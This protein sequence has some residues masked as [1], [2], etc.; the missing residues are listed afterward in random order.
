MGLALFCAIAVP[1]C[2]TQADPDT[3]LVSGTVEAVETELGAEVAGVLKE[4]PVREGDEVGQGQVVAR[5]DPSMYLARLAE[6]RA[7][8]REAEAM[9][10]LS[11][12]GFRKEE[13]LAA[14]NGVSEMEASLENAEANLRRSE[15]LFSQGVVSK[16]DLDEARR[17][18]DVSRA[19]LKSA[20]ENYRKLSSGL[21]TEDIEAARARVERSRA[22]VEQARLD[23]L[24]TEVRSPRPGVV[25]QAIREPG[26]FVIVGTPILTI[27]DLTGD[28]YCWVYLSERELSWV[29]LG[30]EVSAKI[31]AYPDH[32][33]RGKVAFISR[34]A[35]FTPRNVQT[36]EDRVNLV[37]AVKISLANPDGS[38]KVGLP[39]DVELRIRGP[40]EGAAGN[41]P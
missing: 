25:T 19:R 28:I 33:F 36:R 13:I 10:A 6:A 32:R 1:S 14:L 18:A 31:D 37:F 5:I 16:F 11:L 7:A 27:A 24:R 26:E 34:E 39:I 21:R 12:E 8:L 38:L 35:E 30:D 22:A 9:L 23:V 40:G 3:L 17:A 2:R 29:R 41:R 15:D 4:R 20:E